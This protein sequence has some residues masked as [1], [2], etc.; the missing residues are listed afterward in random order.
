MGSVEGD[1]T[2][3]MYVVLTIAIIIGPASWAETA[4]AERFWPSWRGPMDTGVSP[5]GDPPIEWSE[6][7]NIRWKVGP[8]ASAHLT[9]TSIGETSSSVSHDPQDPTLHLGDATLD[10][11]QVRIEKA[12]EAAVEIRRAHPLGD[13]IRVVL[14]GRSILA[15]EAAAPQ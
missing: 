13:G 10:C 7:K 6:E 1:P 9:T 11:G 14:I 2:R 4:D 15:G 3:A 12:S 5:E 8:S